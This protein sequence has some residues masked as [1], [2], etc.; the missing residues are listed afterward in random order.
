MPAA[1]E[2]VVELFRLV[3]VAEMQRPIG[4]KLFDLDFSHLVAD[5]VR[6]LRRYLSGSTRGRCHPSSCGRS[7]NAR[8]PGGRRTR[9]CA[10]RCGSVFTALAGFWKM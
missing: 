4:E 6:R 10:S 8:H 3:L 9:C 1:K 7:C 5:A 2:L